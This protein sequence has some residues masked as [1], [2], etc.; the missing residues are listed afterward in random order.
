VV[1][2][3]AQQRVALLVAFR[4]LDVRHEGHVYKKNFVAV[5]AEVRRDLDLDGG[6]TAKLSRGPEN[7]TKTRSDDR[8]SHRPSFA[9]A[10]RRRMIEAKVEV[11]WQAI[12]PDGNGTITCADFLHASDVMLVQ[13]YRGYSR[14]AIAGDVP[15]VPAGCLRGG[16]CRRCFRPVVLSWGFNFVL[17]CAVLLSLVNTV[18]TAHFVLRG[19]DNAWTG[20]SGGGLGWSTY[21]ETYICAVFVLEMVLTIGAVGWVGY[22]KTSSHVGAGI[23]T[24]VQVMGL[25]VFFYFERE[26]AAEEDGPGLVPPS[27]GFGGG[28]AAG[29]AAADP[30]QGG[31]SLRDRLAN[32]E[33]RLRNESF[34]ISAFVMALQAIRAARLV[35][36][37]RLTRLYATF[38]SEHG[39]TS[40]INLAFET[41]RDVLP[42]LRDIAAFLCVVCYVY[43]IAGM[44]LFGGRI[45][46]FNGERLEGTSMW[47]AGY[48]K[49][50]WV[51]GATGAR[52]ESVRKP[53]LGSGTPFNETFV[54]TYVA[55]ANWNRLSSSFLT[56][57][58]MIIVNNWHVMHEGCLAAVAH[59][60]VGGASALAW[61][62]GT[63]LFF[64][65]FHV[66]SVVVV[67]NILVSTFLDHFLARMRAIEEAET[68][69]LKRMRR[70]A[71]RGRRRAERR[72]LEAP[73]RR[74]LARAVGS[75]AGRMLEM[76]RRRGGGAKSPG[77]RTAHL[78]GEGSARAEGSAPP[79]G[80][81]SHAPPAA[82]R[83]PAGSPRR[84]EAPA[85]SGSDS[86]EERIDEGLDLIQTFAVK[87]L[88][89]S[90]GEGLSADQMSR[91]QAAL[92]YDRVAA[93]ALST[94]EQTPTAAGAAAAVRRARSRAVIE[95]LGSGARRTRERR[96][97]RRGPS[98]RSG[99]QNVDGAREGAGAAA[100]RGSAGSGPAARLAGPQRADI[101][102]ET[103]H[104]VSVFQ[105]L[106]KKERTWVT[107]HVCRY[108]DA[109]LEPPLGRLRAAVR[110]AGAE[111]PKLQVFCHACLSA[112]CLDCSAKRYVPNLCVGCVRRRPKH[113][114]KFC[115]FD[116]QQI[117]HPCWRAYGEGVRRSVREAHERMRATRETGDAAVWKVD[118]RNEQRN[119]KVAS[120]KGADSSL[121]DDKTTSAIRSDTAKV[122]VAVESVFE[123]QERSRA[124]ATAVSVEVE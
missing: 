100:A 67:M 101:M 83:V 26:A 69:D 98:H 57:F 115:D 10:R 94:G 21:L 6:V 33:L 112:V 124:V 109:R 93:A 103:A 64:V 71:A 50:A 108:C 87:L 78:A 118:P 56:L 48:T 117:C 77:G 61:R 74:G 22:S 68:E 116:A 53:P 59:D 113:K 27:D 47:A 70:L 44:I 54:R 20:T 9:E 63:S 16:L 36:L 121:V 123:E 28:A 60:D 18:A 62:W 107:G 79:G 29:Q 32:P 30:A 72:R 76:V 13:L 82:G 5:L 65:S 14:W 97:A 17:D 38:G 31:L 51:D 114:H 55:G 35:R 19:E 11:L 46:V 86:E 39:R 89:R 34:G 92:M 66:V 2:R 106:L 102:S 85:G 7:L 58:D 3:A 104:D 111:T 24:L 120:S 73:R 84:R 99:D 49:Y 41:T 90:Y 23:I 15:E 110:C 8:P 45:T 37:V 52:V 42:A 96:L 122:E 12:D 75:A 95:M 119:Q 43:A 25:L 80:R 1:K 105:A 91:M 40:F 88:R 81:S 4:L